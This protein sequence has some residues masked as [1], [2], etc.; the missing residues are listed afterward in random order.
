MEHDGRRW[1]I[2]C[3]HRDT[4][5]DYAES[6][7]EA[8]AI[9]ATVEDRSQLDVFHDVAG[10]GADVIHIRSPNGTAN[11]TL[12]LRQNAKIL[13]D[14]YNMLASAARAVEN[15]KAAYRGRISGNVI[16]VS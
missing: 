14:A 2:L 3:P 9:F 6:M 5:A 7:A 13:N 1:E 4:I 10:A 15:P 11:G 12:S 16:G 8:I